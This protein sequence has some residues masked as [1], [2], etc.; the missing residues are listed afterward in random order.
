[1]IKY[2]RWPFIDVDLIAMA[3]FNQNWNWLQWKERESERGGE[4]AAICGR[5]LEAIAGLSGG[6]VVM[7]LPTRVGATE[8]CYG[9]PNRPDG[10]LES[11]KQP[12]R[13]G[14]KGAG[15][16]LGGSRRRRDCQ[17]HWFWDEINKRGG[18]FRLPMRVLITRRWMARSCDLG[19]CH[20]RMVRGSGS[21]GSSTWDLSSRSWM[22]S[23]SW[24]TFICDRPKV[25]CDRSR[26]LLRRSFS[27]LRRSFS[28]SRR[29]RRCLA[30]SH[31]TELLPASPVTR[32][33]SA[34]LHTDRL[35]ERY[36]SGAR[37]R[38][39]GEHKTGKQSC[40]EG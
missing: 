15:W 39:G 14:K 32:S 5:W 27:D 13:D 38:R 33:S 21:Q 35:V 26:S 25:D 20:G 23:A 10:R 34:N 17:R 29:D 3:R 1:M 16:R 31:S 12:P 18:G 2:C 22:R 9:P 7:H 28:I 24:V 30:D 6:L 4:S 19:C 8:L 11:F 37:S 40:K 36:D